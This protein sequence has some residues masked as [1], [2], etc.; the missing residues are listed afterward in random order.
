[1]SWRQINDKNPFTWSD[2]HLANVRPSGRYC[3]ECGAEDLSPKGDS[4]KLGRSFNP[5]KT[6]LLK[7]IFVVVFLVIL[8]R[9]YWL[10]VAGGAYYRELS[11]G[12]RIRIRQVE[13]KRGIIYDKDLN[14]LVQNMAMQPVLPI[15][16]PLRTCPVIGITKPCITS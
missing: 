9:L 15:P 13:A 1:M 7:S 8:S 6:V 16:T 2:R 11:D 12:N 5:R 3:L 10:Q 14:P 4:L